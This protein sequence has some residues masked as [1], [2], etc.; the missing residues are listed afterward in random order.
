M[1]LVLRA[2][3]RFK[4][5]GTL[6]LALAFNSACGW[7]VRDVTFCEWRSQS[8]RVGRGCGMAVTTPLGK[9]GAAAAAA[10]AISQRAVSSPE[11]DTPV[12][13]PSPAPRRR[14]C[15]EESSY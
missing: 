1:A 4:F 6:A 9:R 13:T 12:P 5:F 8:S 11:G 10:A 7:L 14:G 3:A 15:K 2:R